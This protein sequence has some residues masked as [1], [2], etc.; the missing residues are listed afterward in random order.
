MSGTTSAGTVAEQIL[1]RINA[2]EAQ[3]A[4]LQL[5]DGTADGRSLESQLE[6]FR[7]TVN[8]MRTDSTKCNLALVDHKDHS[9]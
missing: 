1:G 4:D 9:P 6:Q 2:L 3:V 8:E 7:T 5:N